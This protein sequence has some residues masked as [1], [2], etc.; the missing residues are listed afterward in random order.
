MLEVM[1]FHWLEIVH[2]RFWPV[3]WGQPL[4]DLLSLS[5]ISKNLST[6]HEGHIRV[7]HAPETS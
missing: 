7:G 5:L 2:A 4:Y 3:E 1:W 6:L